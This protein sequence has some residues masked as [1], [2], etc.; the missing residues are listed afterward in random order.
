[1]TNQDVH[2]IGFRFDEEISFSENCEAFLS[3]LHDI[4]AGLTAILR[5]NWD[6]LVTVVQEGERNSR[7]R[8]DFNSK[9]ASALD[10]LIKSAESKDG[11]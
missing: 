4:D 5:D 6:A 8:G 7:A 1:M 9:V 3:S 10:S 11:A 2:S